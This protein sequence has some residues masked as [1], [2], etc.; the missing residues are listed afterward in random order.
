VPFGAVR[1]FKGGPGFDILLV[2][3]Y[4]V[5]ELGYLMRSGFSTGLE[6]FLKGL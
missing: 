6:N 5:S 2:G 4:F 3:I 1:Q